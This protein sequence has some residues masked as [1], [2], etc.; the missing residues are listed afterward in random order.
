MTASGGKTQEDGGG[1]GDEKQ[2]PRTDDIEARHVMIDNQAGGASPSSSSSTPPLPE[3]EVIW[4][5]SQSDKHKHLLKHPVIT[6]FLWLKWKRIGAAYNKNLI[7]Y[8]AFV[9]VLTAFIF[10]SYGGAD[11]LE[12]EACKGKRNY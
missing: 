8:F 2:K 4:H 7:F 9:A 3:T 6:S 5:M 10:L 11:K 12:S 1:A